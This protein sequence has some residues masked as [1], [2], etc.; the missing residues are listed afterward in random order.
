MYL[1]ITTVTGLLLLTIVKY[2]KDKPFGK[3]FVTDHL[4]ITLS[5]SIFG[6]VAFLS[7]AIIIREIVGPFDH[8]I[9]QVV[10][11][12]QQFFNLHLI[13]CLLSMQVAQFCNV[14]FSDR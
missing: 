12:L 6:S 3:Q 1:G 13:M 8:W 5:W 2:L 9:S 4:S 7:A 11:F 10:L 14:F